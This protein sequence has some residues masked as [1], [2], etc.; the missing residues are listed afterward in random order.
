MKDAYT[1]QEIANILERPVQSITR[2]AR[3]EGWQ[4]LPREGRGGGNC[5]IVA[6]MPE[7]TRLAIAARACPAACNTGNA[8]ATPASP[9]SPLTQQGAAK[10]RAHA[11]AA[12]VGS[13]FCQFVHLAGLFGAIPS[14]EIAFFNTKPHAAVRFKKF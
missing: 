11:R 14:F 8:P 13:V 12:S 4:A 7:R 1:S 9:V 5:W 2:A 10:T 6:S 3:R